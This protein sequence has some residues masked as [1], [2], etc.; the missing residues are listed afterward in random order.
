[1]TIEDMEEIVF[2][3]CGSVVWLPKNLLEDKRKTGEPFYCPNGH[4]RRFKET[5]SE[6]LQKELDAARKEISDFSKTSWL[7]ELKTG[8]CPWCWKTVKDLS[9][10]IERKHQ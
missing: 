6:R 8:K 4:S 9:G 5:T 7:T 2:G 3:C 10:H 1:M